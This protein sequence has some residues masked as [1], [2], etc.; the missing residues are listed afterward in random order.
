ME[1]LNVVVEEQQALSM[2]ALGFVSLVVAFSLHPLVRPGRVGQ[3][4][5]QTFWIAQA[6]LGVPGLAM[7][8]LPQLG[9]VALACAIIACVVLLQRLHCE[10][11]LPA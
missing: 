1:I 9:L 7:V 2:L 11:R 8:V 4:M 3:S 10:P 6:V 5:K